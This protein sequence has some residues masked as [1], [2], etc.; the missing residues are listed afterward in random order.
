MAMAEADWTGYEDWLD[1]MA[2]V[3]DDERTI[4]MEVM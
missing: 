3:S 1:S 2:T 4:I